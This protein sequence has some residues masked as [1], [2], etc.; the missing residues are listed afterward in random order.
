MLGQRYAATVSVM[1]ALAVS[2]V[3]V[4]ASRGFAQPEPAFVVPA[5]SVMSGS[6]IGER[7]TDTAGKHR[8]EIEQ[9]VIEPKSGRI[10]HVVLGVGGLAGLGES[11][12]VV[13]WS[14]LRFR[15]DPAHPRR[16]IVSVDPSAIDRAP[17]W[18]R[19][20]ADR[21]VLP[22]AASPQTIPPGPAPPLPPG[23]R[24]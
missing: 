2:I 9:L 5:E 19:R 24:Y 16:T 14:D 21:D 8:G 13:K 17:R 4:G 22:P 10:S 15:P 18:Q 20:T 23:K 7:V 6:L 12:M 11:K 3:V 1:A